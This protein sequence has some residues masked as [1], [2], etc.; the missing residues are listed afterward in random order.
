M[1]SNQ[2]Q[3]WQQRNSNSATTQL[4]TQPRSPPCS[5]LRWSPARCRRRPAPRRRPGC[6]RVEGSG[7]SRCG[8][9]SECA[10]TSRGLGRRSIPACPRCRKTPFLRSPAA[11]RGTGPECSSMS[12]EMKE[13][14]MSVRRIISSLTN[15]LKFCSS[16]GF[17]WR[18]HTL[19][20]KWIFS[21]ASELLGVV[22][23]C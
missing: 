21:G 13:E 8:K 4:N 9:S 1:T 23:T 2:Q 22:I 19:I 20:S 12:G 10:G 14:E 11:C 16:A 3:V 17:R 5:S 6:T 18:V 15:C 7:A